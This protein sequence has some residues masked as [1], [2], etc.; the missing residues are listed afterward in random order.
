[1]SGQRRHGKWSREIS[2]VRHG[3][4]DNGIMYKTVDNGGMIMCIANDS[5]NSSSNGNVKMVMTWRRWGGGRKKKWKILM[6]SSCCVLCSFSIIFSSFAFACSMYIFSIFSWYFLFLHSFQRTSS[7]CMLLHATFLFIIAW[8]VSLPDMYMLYTYDLFLFV[9]T[10]FIEA[11]LYIFFVHVIEHRVTRWPLLFLCQ[12]SPLWYFCCC[13][14]TAVCIVIPLVAWWWAV[15]R[16]VDAPPH[17]YRPCPLWHC[18]C[19]ARP[20]HYLPAFP[21]TDALCIVI[22]AFYAPYAIVRPVVVL[23]WAEDGRRFRPPPALVACCCGRDVAVTLIGGDGG[24]WSVVPTCLYAH[25][26]SRGDGDVRWRWC[27]AL[28]ALPWQQQAPARAPL[29]RYPTPPLPA[30]AVARACAPPPGARP[31][32][33]R[34]TCAQRYRPYPHP[35]LRVQRTCPAHLPYIAPSC[36]LPHCC[37]CSTLCG[38]GV[39]VTMVVCSLYSAPSPCPVVRYLPPVDG[40]RWIC[41]WWVVITVHCYG[42]WWWCTVLPFITNTIVLYATTPIYILLCMYCLPYPLPSIFIHYCTSFINP[43]V[44]IIPLLLFIFYLIIV[45]ANVEGILPPANPSRTLMNIVLYMS[46]LLHSIPT[47]LNIHYC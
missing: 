26:P 2:H 25:G 37:C 7:C 5:S 40:E 9:R 1:M 16:D 44:Y 42:D 47:L 27:P 22:I 19:R 32:P 34:R 6:L 45:Y 28:A 30:P 21:T 24:G 41:C 38:G 15:I 12:P 23:T 36:Q 20:A 3:V 18:C 39:V 43:T 29:C 10:S 11:L 4:D 46:F 13:S 14:V 31:S 35:C 17:L 33:L 8:P